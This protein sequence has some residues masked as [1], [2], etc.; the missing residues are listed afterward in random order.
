MSHRA[1][2]LPKNL[3]VGERQRVAIARALANDPMILMADEPTGNLDTATAQ[4]IFEL[5]AQLH[6][7]QKKTLVLV[8]HDLDLA[9]RAER[10]VR[11]QDGRLSDE[12]SV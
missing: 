7:E 4:Q 5:F 6:R 10:I 12:P 8:T 9:R 11:M 3:S 1:N 2:H